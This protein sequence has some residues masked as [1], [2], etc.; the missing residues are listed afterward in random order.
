MSRWTL[1]EYGLRLANPL[2]LLLMTWRLADRAAGQAE[3][4]AGE[5]FFSGALC[6]WILRIATAVTFAV[7]GCK[8]WLA[9]PTFVTMVIASCE[10][11]LGTWPEQS[12][13]EPILRVICVADVAVA[14]LV[15][16]T[17]WPRVAAYAALWGLVTALARMTSSTMGWPEALLR[18][19]HIGGPLALYLQWRTAAATKE[20]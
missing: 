2:V 8:A 1:A 19:A 3:Q 18:A 12:L 10:N 11:L 20:S 15:L 4:S 13:V 16:V 17:R 9:A 5:P 14:I 7:H 6:E